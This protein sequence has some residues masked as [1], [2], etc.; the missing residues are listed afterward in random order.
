MFK[1]QYSNTIN[2]KD[3]K[4]VNISTTGN[5]KNRFTV[6]LPFTADGGKLPPYVIFKRMTMMTFQL[7]K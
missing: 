4:T 2:K 5:E 3:A 1:L 6:M 7:V